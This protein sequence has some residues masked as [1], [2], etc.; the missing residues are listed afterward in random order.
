MTVTPARVLAIAIEPF[1]GQ[2][3]SGEDGPLRVSVL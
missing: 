2:A 1:S 3:Q